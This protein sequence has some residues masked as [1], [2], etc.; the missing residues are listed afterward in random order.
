MY[1]MLALNR[2]TIMDKIHIE[3]FYHQ[4]TQTFCH[5]ITDAETKSSALVDPVMDYSPAGGRFGYEF[6]DSVLYYIKSNQLQL[7]WVLE[8]HIHA[9]HLTAAQY[10]K[11]HTGAKVVSGTSVK[12]VQRYFDEM[13]DLNS[14]AESLFDKLVESG[15]SLPLGAS[16]IE[17]MATP[18]HTQSCLT[19]V[20]KN[21]EGVSAFIGDTLFM[22]DIG[23]ARCD[24]PGGSAAVL[25]DSIQNIYA[26]GDKAELYLC[27]DYPPSSRKA[28]ASVCV[29]AQ[30][31][32]NIHCGQD[33][34]KEQFINIRAKRDA[35]LAPPRLLLPSLQVNIR[36]G[37]LPAADAQ[38]RRF[39]RIP[40]R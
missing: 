29:A 23:S 33:T 37:V 38:G 40:L 24:F 30:K 35:S 20:L 31:Q 2:W 13:F 9:D 21:Q 28:V 4:D 32:N 15:D 14:C 22:P 27:H 26:L 12:S 6:I 10:V 19:Y 25:F 3:S 8:T 34:D 11:E 7:L 17:V 1:Y 39:L 5:L 36:A 18:G 16:N